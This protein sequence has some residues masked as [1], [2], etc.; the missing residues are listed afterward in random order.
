[1]RMT[2]GR[3]DFTL[4]YQPGSLMVL[5]DTLSRAHP[6]DDNDSRTSEYDVNALSLLPASKA[7][8]EEIRQ[9]TLHDPVMQELK[10]CIMHGWPQLRNLVGEIRH[11]YSLRDSL[12]V[13][14]DIILFGERL[15][16]PQSLRKDMKAKLH[17][18]HL[19]Q[20]SMLRRARDLIFW[21]KMSAEIRQLVM[22]C[23]TCQA[24]QPRQVKEPLI[25]HDKG[26][27]PFQKVGCDIFEFR[28]SSYLVTVD[29]LS[30]FWEVDYLPTTTSASIITKLKAHFARYGIPQ[31]LMSDNGPNLV[32][33]EFEQFLSKWGI[34]HHTSSPGFSQSNG[35]AESAVKAAKTMMKKCKENGE[36]LHLSLL[37]NR[38]TPIETLNQS[39][40][41]MMFQRRTNSIMPAAMTKLMPSLSKPAKALNSR[42]YMQKKKYDRGKS[43]LSSLRPGTRV[44]FN[45]QH[46]KTKPTW[47][48]GTIVQQHSSPRSYVIAD[49]TG[50]EYR[51]N[52]VDIR[53]TPDMC[54]TGAPHVSRAPTV[55]PPVSPSVPPVSPPPPVSPTVPSQAPVSG[56]ELPMTPEP[57]P[58]RPTRIRMR[59]RYLADY[60]C[61]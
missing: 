50:C 51:R 38:N 15:V 48:S 60:Q 11:Y 28:N 32:S 17:T 8:L 34:E 39:P 41:Q 36:D 20:E 21:P 3:Y 2:L 40:A 29:Y 5:P 30:S 23:Q 31:I 12:T 19:G 26:E 45:V 58:T 18:S 44:N 54:E 9:A 57:T 10:K 27:Y 49:D 46:G 33:Q 52:R 47:R 4:Q 25:I 7:R 56:S 14:D 37:E 59:P 61:S 16:I 24:H 42:A 13:E 43:S 35:K 6:S 22:S 55:S 53:E 1:M